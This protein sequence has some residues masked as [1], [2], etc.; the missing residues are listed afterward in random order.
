M[1]AGVR[2]SEAANFPREVPE[3]FIRIR[4]SI[5]RT[6]SRPKAIIFTH[7]DLYLQVACRE[8]AVPSCVAINL[9]IG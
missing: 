9:A 5:E 7:A 8:L 2:I 1:G 6:S 4:N 3:K